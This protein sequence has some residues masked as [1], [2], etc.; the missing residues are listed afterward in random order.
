MG[1]CGQA[2]ACLVGLRGP[3][4]FWGP[5][6]APRPTYHPEGE[7]LS[8]LFPHHEVGPQVAPRG[9]SVLGG[10]PLLEWLLQAFELW[11]RQKQTQGLKLRSAATAVSRGLV[12][13]GTHRA[14]PKRR[15][16]GPTRPTESRRGRPAVLGY[17]TCDRA[18]A[19]PALDRLEP[20]LSNRPRLT[21]DLCAHLIC[22][23]TVDVPPVCPRVSGR[24]W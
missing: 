4:A 7:N 1:A 15:T 13:K 11:I 17:C 5:K 10:F 2:E 14:G 18:G 21:L 6:G 3:E 24:P 22:S 16:C 23:Q 8:C 19:R 12:W 9:L 20:W